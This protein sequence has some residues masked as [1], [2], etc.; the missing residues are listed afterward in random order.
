[1]KR[2]RVGC[3]C[4]V[5]MY[6]YTSFF[7]IDGGT[8]AMDTGYFNLPLTVRF[9]MLFS[10][11]NMPEEAVSMY[12]HATKATLYS[13]YMSCTWQDRNQPSWALQSCRSLLWPVN[14]QPKNKIGRPNESLPWSKKC[15]R[16]MFLRWWRNLGHQSGMLLMVTQGGQRT[17]HHECH[18]L[19]KKQLALAHGWL[20]WS[21]FCKFDLC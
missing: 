11:A 10:L 9:N 15:W 5:F 16:S 4:I 3:K 6:N 8:S 7:N 21:I 14:F 13:R 19:N 2:W 1:M 20:L 12:D 17:W 18:V